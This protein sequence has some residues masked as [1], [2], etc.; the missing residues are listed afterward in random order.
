MIHRRPDRYG[1]L[2]SK[3]GGLGTTVHTYIHTSGKVHGQSRLAVMCLGFE[4]WW[5]YK[6]ILNLQNL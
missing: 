1:N 5:I 2:A 6:W 4:E 3:V